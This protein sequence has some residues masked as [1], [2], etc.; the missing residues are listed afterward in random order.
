MSTYHELVSRTV[1]V[2]EAV[3]ALI[4]VLGGGFVLLR[5]AVSAV[6][7]RPHDQA[8]ER[9]RG[10]LGRAILLGLE[11][12]IV[13]DIVRTIVVEQTLANVGALGAIVII[14]TVLSFSLDVEI[15]GE[16]PWRRKAGEGD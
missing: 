1:E 15:E 11:V 14:R 13:A 7:R 2:I 4:M 5:Y 10:D 16:L 9:L 3:G 8:Y 6:A 12:L